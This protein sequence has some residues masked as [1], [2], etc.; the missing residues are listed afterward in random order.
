MKT[1]SESQGEKPFDWNK[2]LENPSD[3]EPGYL[4]DLSMSWVTC[5]CGNQC[6]V[7]LRSEEEGCP[8]DPILCKLGV[9]F[10]NCIEFCEWHM[11][12]KVLAQIE[13]RS[14]FIINQLSNESK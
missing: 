6:D 4:N 10:N 9:D 2:A 1:Y 3:Y 14:A 12:K 8:E 5:A 11:A 13:E 7:I